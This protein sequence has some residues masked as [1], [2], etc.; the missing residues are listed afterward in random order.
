M[1][2]EMNI[3]DEYYY[4]VYNKE[5]VYIKCT[6]DISLAS[7]LVDQLEGSYTTTMHYVSPPSTADGGDT[8]FKR[9]NSVIHL[10]Y[11]TIILIILIIVIFST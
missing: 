2:K 8:Y 11:F 7:L 1:I 5:G 4:T 3:I 9:D 10:F 6:Q